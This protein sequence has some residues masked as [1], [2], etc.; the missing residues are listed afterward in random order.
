MMPR[1]NLYK[2]Q[3]DVMDL[4]RKYNIPYVIKPMGRAFYDILT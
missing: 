3:S 4:C 1:H 2:I